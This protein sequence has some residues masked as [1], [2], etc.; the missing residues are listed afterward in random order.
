MFA[1]D[2]RPEDDLVL[3][4]LLAEAALVVLRRRVH[5]LD[6]L[7]SRGGCFEQLIGKEA[8]LRTNV[9]LTILSYG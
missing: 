4:D 9:R 3:D 8:A 1:V 2:V 7:P 5:Y 6:V